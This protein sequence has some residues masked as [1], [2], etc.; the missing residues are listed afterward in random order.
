LTVGLQ[1]G[2]IQ[3][4]D[5]GDFHTEHRFMYFITPKFK[6]SDLGMERWKLGPTTVTLENRLD[7]RIRHYKPHVQT[8]RY[9][10]KPELAY[11]VYNTE[12]LTVSPYVSDAFYFDF[13]DGIGFNQNRIY[14]G[15]KLALLKHI[16]LGFYYMRKLDRSGNGGP[17]TGTNVLGTSAGYDF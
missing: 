3:E 5:P 7:W 1:Y 14:G 12:K 10:F 17:W 15:L 6:L 8:W 9:R 11:P 4:G 16:K 13:T 2:N